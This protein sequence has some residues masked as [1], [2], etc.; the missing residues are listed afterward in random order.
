MLMV[1]S[2]VM[3]LEERFELL[4]VLSVLSVPGIG[5]GEWPLRGG[6]VERE[7]FLDLRDGVR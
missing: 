1:S 6:V 3:S 7:D 2:I 5:G 4:S